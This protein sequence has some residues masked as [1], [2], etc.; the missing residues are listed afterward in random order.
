MWHSAESIFSSNLV[1]DLRKCES[2]CKTVLAHE[3]GDPG[4]QLT[5][6]TEGRKSRDTVPLIPGYFQSFN[7]A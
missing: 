7:F 4:V 1:E 6:K 2:I 3:S 5:K